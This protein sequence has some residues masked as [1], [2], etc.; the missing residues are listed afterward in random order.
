MEA[1]M[2]GH[3]LPL[4][5]LESRRPVR[6]FDLVGVT[7]QYEMSF[8][9]ILNLLDL[10]GIPL[11]AADRGPQDPF[12]IAGGPCAFNPEPVAGFFDFIVL[13]E[14]EEVVHEIVDAYK[15]WRGEGRPADRLAFLA[16]TAAIPGVYV[17]A[18]YDVTYAPDGRI[19]AIIPNRPGVPTV[20]QKRVVKDLDELDYPT[21]PIVPFLDIVHDR[22]MIEVFRGCTRGCRF[23]Q[24]GAIYR[25]VRE[26]SAGKVKSLAADL[27]R[28]TGY[29]EISLTSL[30]TT[31]Y[32]AI[33][34]ALHA[35]IE[36]HGPAGVGVSLPSLRVD[37][38]DVNLARE[39]QKVRKTGLT[40]APEAGT[41][42]LRDVINKGVTEEDLMR[43]A[44]A[45]FSAGW[46]GLKLYFMIGLP[47]ETEADLA[48]IV[49]LARKIARVYQEATSEQRGPRGNRR[50]LRLTVSVSSFVPKAHTPFQWEP[51]DT[52]ETLRRKQDFLRRNL[53]PRLADLNWH[54]ARVSFIE[55]VFARGDRR[56]GRVLLAAHRL[57]CRFDSWSDQFR[58]D[59]W[60]A[61][62]QEAG[63]DPA[64]YANRPRA[65][66]EVLP[67]DHLTSGVTREFFIDEH[68]RAMAGE[69]TPD[70]RA[71]G[72]TLCG[73]CPNLGADLTIKGGVGAGANQG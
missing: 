20:V 45:A 36:D 66:D 18:F 19:E 15:K 12:V 10:A 27:V 11:L 71:A 41:Q 72:C 49:D 28:R 59:A 29:N 43:T 51:Q 64:S 44:R 58:F 1:V 55:G 52:L 40:F 42:R 23:C 5:A 37:A 16:R 70:C 61:A 65:Y 60:L 34:E 54:D 13:G 24:A 39:V 26:R 14:G 3:G 35:L 6:E 22:I 67:W 69:T 25:P 9:N 33:G 62:F 7:L 57:G 31:D 30:S 21:R 4:F 32:S 47:T 56:L 17:P 46:N 38:F 48:G 73:A 50:N 8:S 53:P 2:R 68:R 63:L